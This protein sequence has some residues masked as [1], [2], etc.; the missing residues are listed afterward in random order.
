MCVPR[1]V[2]SPRRSDKEGLPAQRVRSKRLSRRPHAR[3]DAVTVHH[4]DWE[5]KRGYGETC[6]KRQRGDA[7]MSLCGRLGILET[8]DDSRRES[9]YEHV[10]DANQEHRVHESDVGHDERKLEA[11]LALRP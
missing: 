2:E 10:R 3:R 9:R 1:H 4:D 11:Q 5:Q 8:V 6:S 7:K